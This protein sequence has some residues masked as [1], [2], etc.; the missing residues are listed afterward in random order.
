MEI[1]GPRYVFTLLGINEA[2]AAQGVFWLWDHDEL[3][4]AGRAVGNQTIRACLADHCAGDYGPC[5]QRATHYA[6]ETS[7]YPVARQA[8]ILEQF[9]KQHGRPPRCQKT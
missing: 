7:N 1:A 9:E 5:T 4:Y 6:W 3:I 8:E 2:P